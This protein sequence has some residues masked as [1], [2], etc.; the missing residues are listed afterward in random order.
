MVW[1][2]VMDNEHKTQN[3]LLRATEVAE[4]LDISR[5]M[6]YRLIQ[7]GEIRSVHIGMARRVRL[8]DL[9]GYIETNLHPHP[10]FVK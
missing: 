7:T 8:E 3:K 2:F 10:D 5:S 1:S 4:I 6:A 9:Q